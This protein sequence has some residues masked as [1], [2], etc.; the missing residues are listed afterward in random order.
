VLSVGGRLQAMRMHELLL[1]LGV[2]VILDVVVRPPRQLRRDDRPP[3][4]DGGEE[5]ADDPILVVGEVAV[6]YVGPQVVEPPQPAALAAPLQPCT[7]RT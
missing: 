1:E 5:A 3:A 6:L 2:P 7:R 4:P